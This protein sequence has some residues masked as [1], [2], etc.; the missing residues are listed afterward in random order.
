MSDKLRPAMLHTWRLFITTHA[1]MI[2]HIDQQLAATGKIPLHWYDVLI[3]LYEAPQQ[4]LRMNE[5]ATLVLLTRSGLTRLVDKLEAAG[6]LHRELDPEDR[7]GF[8]ASISTTGIDAMREA[9]PI[10]AAS[11]ADYFG[12]DLDAAEQS[13]LNK[14]FDRILA[15]LTATHE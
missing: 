14:L 1:K 8:Y 13:V 5:L 9:W 2:G 3:E 6:Y 15:R 7:R 11:I 10:Y 4:R 12:T